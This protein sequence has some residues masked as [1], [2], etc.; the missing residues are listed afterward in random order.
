MST[1]DLHGL[2]GP[3]ALDALDPHERTSFEFHLDQC[4]E[5]REELSG[6]LETAAR[7][8]Q[9]E[10]VSPPPALRAQILDAA[11]QTSQHRPVV[12]LAQRKIRRRVPQLV[13]AA[14]IALALAGGTTAVVQSQR[15]NDLET[16]NSQM[17]SVLTAEDVTSSSGS[18]KDG[19]TVRVLASKSHDAAVVVGAALP[20]LSDGR[21]YQV[22]TMHD[23]RPKPAGVIGSEP[24]MVYVPKVGTA[25]AVAVT[26]EPAG[27]SER[28]TTDAI[29]VTPVTA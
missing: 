24:G 14:A 12:E 5:C 23:G 4:A 9:T 26:V 11:R 7:L 15:V 28:P 2:I 16:A 3:Y 6:F 25:D 8:G 21:V 27:G 19:G 13:A 20:R 17:K 10:E 22:W 1:T 29:A 18:T